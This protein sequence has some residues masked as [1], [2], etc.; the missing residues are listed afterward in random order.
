MKI[1]RKV[2]TF[3]LYMFGNFSLYDGIFTHTHGNLVHID[4]KFTPKNGKFA[5]LLV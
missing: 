2:C 3:N 1:V 4:G 5:P